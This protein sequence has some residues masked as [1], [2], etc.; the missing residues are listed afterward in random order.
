MHVLVT[1]ASRHGATIEIASAIGRELELAGHSVAVTRPEAVG[2]LDG[3]D[4]VVL[5]S[6]VYMGR[7]LEPSR[8]L[9]DRLRDGFATRPVWLFS[10]GP[11][12][13]PPKP[14]GDPSD[15]PALLEATHARGHRV[16]A[17]VIA[18]RNLG[19]GEKAMTAALR[20]PDGDYRPWPEIQSWARSIAAA[21]K[22]T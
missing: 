16:F 18:R 10:S 11:A 3:Y 19:L 1:A 17:G 14:E 21:L 2:S 5:G 13:D 7:W 22:E 6:A 4:A 12:G 9:V 15:V 20:V 8:Q